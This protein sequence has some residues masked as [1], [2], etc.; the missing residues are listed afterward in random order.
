MTLIDLLNQDGIPT[1]RVSGTNGGE[2]AGPCPSCGGTDRFRAWPGQGETGRFWCRACG[3]QGDA[4]QYLRDFRGLSYLEACHFLGREPKNRHIP[5]R[6]RGMKQAH[7]RPSSPTW[8]PREYPSPGEAWT[9][10]AGRF[11]A[12]AEGKLW[13]DQ[14]KE[15]RAWLHGRGLSEETIRSFH[16]GW[17][18]G[19]LWRDRGTWGLPEKPGKDGKPKKLW[20]PLGL[21]IPKIREGR[22]VRV[23]IRRPEGEPRYYLV[24]GS[25]SG[26][27]IIPGGQACA[28]VESELDAILV[29]Q[30]AGDLVTTIALGSASLRPDRAAMEVIRG[31]ETVLLALDSDDA[32]ARQAWQ[33]WTPRFPNAQYWPTIYGKD[34]S[35]ARQNGLDL[36]AWVEAA[37]LPDLPGSDDDPGDHPAGDEGTGGEL[38]PR[39]G[40][41]RGRP[42]VAIAELVHDDG[43]GKPPRRV[44]C[45]KCDHL[46][47]HFRC[48]KGHRMPG[49]ELLHTCPSFRAGREDQGGTTRR[50]PASPN[51]QNSAG[52]DQPEDLGEPPAEYRQTAID[53]VA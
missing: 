34:P 47:E 49:S 19:D 17:N 40:G 51:L 53:G 29:H 5:I 7:T 13:T 9:E 21:V 22:V 38:E 30:D 8:E 6:G 28:V 31:A 46:D 45:R 11:V 48:T 26:P 20:L 43:P 32:G 44:K 36:R 37:L 10:K 52:S 18:P 50:I 14:G 3:K 41:D 24:P 2:Y 39:T 23:R 33:E 35:E 4:V 25:E 27:L 1:R 12:W 16:L 15:T 42:L